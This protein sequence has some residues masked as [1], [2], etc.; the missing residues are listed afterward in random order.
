MWQPADIFRCTVFFDSEWFCM[1]GF[2]VFGCEFCGW[3]NSI[4]TSWWVV[5]LSI[6]KVSSMLGG[7]KPNHSMKALAGT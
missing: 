1:C 6:Y 5:G 4:T 3:T 7:A 2:D